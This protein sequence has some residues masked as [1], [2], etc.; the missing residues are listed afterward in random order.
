MA[1]PLALTGRCLLKFF[2]IGCAL[3]LAQGC[4][5]P[6]KSRSEV[7][8]PLVRTYSPKTTSSGDP[9]RAAWDSEG[10]RQ[11]SLAQL[12]LLDPPSTFQMIDRAVSRHRQAQQDL[13]AQRLF[14]QRNAKGRNARSARSAAGKKGYALGKVDGSRRLEVVNF[15]QPCT[16]LSTESLLSTSRPAGGPGSK[17]CFIGGQGWAPEPVSTRSMWSAV[18]IKGDVWQQVRAGLQFKAV[19]NPRIQAHLD[20]LK[21][22]PGT[23]DF[24]MARAEPYLHY[25]MGELKRQ[26]LPADLV[27]VP[28]IE[29]AFQTTA[30]SPKQAAGLWQ[31][32]PST[33][34]Q[35]GLQLSET[36]DGRYD[37][38]L[39]TGAA[40]RYL[41]YL[42]G[43]FHG[44][45][46]L[47]L[48][49]YNAGEGTVT[50][51]I[52]ASR[53]AG[54]TGAFWELD[55]P[56]ETQNYVVKILVLSKVIANPA[57][58]GFSQRSAGMGGSLMRVEAQ[59]DVRIQ[60]LIVRSGI[61]PADFFRLNPAYRPDIQPPREA[62]N[63]LLP[64][65]KAEVLMAANLR[66]AKVYVPKRVIVQKGD[67]LEDLARK[68]GVSQIKLLEL[69]SISP[70]SPLKPGQELLVHGV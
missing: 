60:D 36:Y 25:L 15:Y 66:G 39:A 24:L 69:N 47:T 10:E 42:N 48:A 27:L 2:C 16:R 23:V 6:P 64:L 43:L 53:Q 62:H 7:G 26:N 54:G 20:Y 65:E 22:K 12:S 31:F 5:T 55:L 44:D 17:D 51:A 4:T 3:I 70:K 52:Q 11:M 33:G 9:W 46:L 57:A 19:Q 28:M 13:E 14:I 32:V 63:F 68:H 50:R 30:L 8:K 56:Q 61:A 41:R 45:W 37:T 59:P 29:S 58:Y 67:T 34:H 21:T 40:L 18:Q 49:A 1:F 38:H 35:Y